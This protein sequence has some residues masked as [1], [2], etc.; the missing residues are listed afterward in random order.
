LPPSAGV[1]VDSSVTVGDIRIRAIPTPHANVEHYS[2]RVDWVGQ[3]LYFVGDTDDPA[4]LLAQ[5]R[6]DVAFVTPWLWQT[7]RARGA[8]IDARNIVIYHHRSGESVSGCTGACRVPR[9]G[10]RWALSPD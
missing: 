6:L 7:V 9:Q 1:A 4:A 8:R 3:S 2:Y 5:R 10:E